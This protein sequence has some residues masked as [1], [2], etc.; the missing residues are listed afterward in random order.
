MRAE[1]MVTQALGFQTAEESLKY[2]QD[3]FYTE[4]SLL[5]SIK[6]DSISGSSRSL[7]RLFEVM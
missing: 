1:L 2:I 5:F 7:F 4:F 6:T 3:G